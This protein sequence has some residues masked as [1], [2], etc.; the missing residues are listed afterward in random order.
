MIISRK[1]SSFLN[2]LP[3]LSLN[4]FSLVR[5]SSFKYLGVLIS[6]DLSW[7]PHIHSGCSKAR[8]VSGCLFQYFYHH[9]SPKILLKLYIALFLPHLTYC[10]SVW[11]PP[12]SSLDSTLLE[13]TQFFSL[14]ICS[15]S[16]NSS[17]ST[18]LSL[19]D[20]P[21]LS[22]LR[23]Q[24]KLS[25]LFKILNQSIYFSHNTFIFKPPP[26]HSL[27]SYDSLTL[28]VPSLSCITLIVILYYFYTLFIPAL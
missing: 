3:T 17:Y 12:K 4:N 8:Q 11:D 22:T 14:K 6:S 13:K 10:S 19:F 15:H 26:T 21:T 2:S 23:S 25:L 16:W 5:V 20:L 1:K 9:A 18:L 7:S 27:R 28:I 24:A